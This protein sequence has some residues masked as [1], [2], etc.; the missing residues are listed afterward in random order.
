MTPLRSP[1]DG[2]MFVRA[3]IVGRCYW[4]GE[5]SNRE[6]LEAIFL[7]DDYEVKKWFV[8]T[9]GR[10]NVNDRRQVVVTP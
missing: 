4:H 7:I 9:F 5:D 2:G 8:T 10:R 6:M 3:A 1:V